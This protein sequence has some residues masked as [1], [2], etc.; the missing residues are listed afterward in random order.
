MER[1]G[2]MRAGVGVRQHSAAGQVASYA[3]SV[4]VSRGDHSTLL[5]LA[6][7][8]HRR[9]V[10]VVD[11]RFTSPGAGRRTFQATI[12]ATAQQAS[13]VEATLRNVVVV[14]DAQVRF[15]ET[16]SAVPREAGR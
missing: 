13:I 15:L 11:A 3:V 2:V 4:S 7:A 1:S 5:S 9:H 10:D 8:L 14:T 12:L 6:S 16:R